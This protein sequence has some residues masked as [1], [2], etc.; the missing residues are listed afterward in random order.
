MNIYYIDNKGLHRIVHIGN[1]IFK[2]GGFGEQD[3]MVSQP[4]NNESEGALIYQYF[5]HFPYLVRSVHIFIFIDRI[6]NILV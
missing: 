2:F 6:A 1:E 5:P 3:H 4:L